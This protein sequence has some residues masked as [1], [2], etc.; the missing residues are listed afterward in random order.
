MI[1]V[2][3]IVFTVASAPIYRRRGRRGRRRRQHY[4][5]ALAT[6]WTNENKIRHSTLGAE[7]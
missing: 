6:K 5:V 2:F 3:G 7:R 1:V 4:T